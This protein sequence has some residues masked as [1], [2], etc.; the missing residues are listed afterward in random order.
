[1]GSIIGMEAMQKPFL[2]AKGLIPASAQSN[3]T[4]KLLQEALNYAVFIPFA[5]GLMAGF[6][7]D[8]YAKN[9][10]A[11]QFNVRW[12]HLAKQYQGIVA[13]TDR[14]QRILRRRNKN[15]H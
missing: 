10:P 1:M 4:L 15:A 12:W 13:P 14:G 7:H 8:L 11:D 6:E 3:D 2:Q 5:S 9:L